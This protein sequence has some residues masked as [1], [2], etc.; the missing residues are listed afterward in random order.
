MGGWEWVVGWGGDQYKEIL[1]KICP[2]K[3]Y[4][5]IP[6]KLV[7]NLQQKILQ[8]N[9]LYFWYGFILQRIPME[10]QITGKSFVK[11]FPIL[12]LEIEFHSH[13]KVVSPKLENSA[14]LFISK[15]KCANFER[16]RRSFFST[17]H[18]HPPPPSTTTIHHPSVKKKNCKPKKAIKP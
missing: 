8:K 1:C 18:H 6:S 17:I 13:K 3:I 14:H 12:K 7:E 15:Y 16:N 4:K 9:S 11:F 5:G 2:L 10:K